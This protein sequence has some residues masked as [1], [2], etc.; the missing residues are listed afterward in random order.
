MTLMVGSARIDENGNIA[1]G[2]AGDQTGKEVSTQPYYMHKKG[3]ILLRPKDAK[4]ANALAF[5]MQEACA[6]GNIGYDQNER[7]NVLPLLKKYGTLG[8]IAEPCECDC[9]SLVRACC[10]QTGF[11]PGNFNTSSETSALGATGRFTNMGAV[12]ANTVIYAGDVLVTQTKG[13]TVIVVTG[14]NRDEKIAFET[15]PVKDEKPVQIVSKPTKP[16]P[17]KSKDSDLAGSYIVTASSLNIRKGPGVNYDSMA[18]LRN[19]T[20]CRCYGYYTEEK[21]V[22]WLLVIADGLEGYVSSEYLDKQ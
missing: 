6:N 10:I 16:I 12:N 15:T 5:A 9:S 20:K 3:W 1:G 17:A 2:K 18:K 21:Q 22:K 14:R 7:L 8:K 13:H 19:G 11:D 4:V